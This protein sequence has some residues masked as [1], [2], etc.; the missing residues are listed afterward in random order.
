MN[1]HAERFNRN[2]Q[3]QFMDY[4][5]DQLL[6]DLSGFNRKLADWLVDCN[7]V[8]PHHSLGLRSLAT[9]SSIINPSAKGG[10]LIHQDDLG[11]ACG[12]YCS[13]YTCVFYVYDSA[14]FLKPP[15]LKED[16]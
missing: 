4:H 6:H 5:E 13:V 9:S 2:I 12:Y 1:T 14:Y 16:I 7:T 10:G 3:E 11:V 8:L 15:L